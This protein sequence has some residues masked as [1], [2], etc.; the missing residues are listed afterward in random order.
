MTSRLEERVE[1]GSDGGGQRQRHCAQ[2]NEDEGDERMN[3]PYDY[4]GHGAKDR[5]PGEAEEEASNDRQ[6]VIDSF[7]EY[8]NI[9]SQ[10]LVSPHARECDGIHAYRHAYVHT[11]LCSDSTA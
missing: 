7:L 8:E 6:E 2:N 4:E 3:N 10:S 1:K 11:I 5:T 9:L